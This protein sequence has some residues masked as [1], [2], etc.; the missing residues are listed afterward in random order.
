M[1]G[2]H[3]LYHEI[4]N[5]YFN[6]PWKDLMT[7]Q[8]HPFLFHK[9]IKKSRSPDSSHSSWREGGANLKLSQLGFHLVHRLLLCCSRVG[10]M[11]IA[12]LNAKQLNWWLNMAQVT[13]LLQ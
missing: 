10:G 8:T 1:L 4:I 12:S 3:F 6:N 11:G 7:L 9:A 5:G 13:V 2:H